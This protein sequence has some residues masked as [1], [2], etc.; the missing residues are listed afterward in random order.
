MRIYILFQDL[1]TF[2]PS[3]THLFPCIMYML[4]VYILTR[5]GELK[6]QHESRTE[7]RV[8]TRAYERELDKENERRPIQRVR[9]RKR[10]EDRETRIKRARES[11]G[12]R[13]R[14]CGRV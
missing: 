4:C 9:E 13:V 1:A 10:K 6:F 2:W 8:L 12:E 3:G 11:E 5:K 14:V 7:H